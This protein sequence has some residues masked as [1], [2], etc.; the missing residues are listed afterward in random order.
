MPLQHMDELTPDAFCASLSQTPGDA[1][2]FLFNQPR[3]SAIFGE[4]EIRD[5]NKESSN[6]ICF[7]GD[8]VAHA[9]GERRKWS[10]FSRYGSTA[11]VT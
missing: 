1:A 8:Q 10:C 9:R 3:V 6:I 5:E 4:T 2:W 11:L 7:F